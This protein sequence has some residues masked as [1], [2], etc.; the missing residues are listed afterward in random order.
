MTITYV[1]AGTAAHA[2]AT[3]VTPGLPAGISAADTLLVIDALKAD[4]TVADS[5]GEY[6][7]LATVL[8]STSRR[9]TVLGKT[10]DGS[11]SAPQIDITGTGNSH[12][13]VM[14]ALR[15]AYQTIASAVHASAGQA[16]DNVDLTIE[17]PA[18]TITEDNCAV[19][20]VISHNDDLASGALS[21]STPAGFTKVGDYDT[22][23]GGDHSFAIYEQIQTTATSISAGTV[24]K[25]GGGGA[26][27]A[28]IILA[29]KASV[30]NRYVKLLANAVAASET[31]IEGVVLNAARDTVIGEFSGQAFE[32]SLEGGEAVLLIPTN[33]ITPNGESLTTSDTPTVFAYNAT[34]STIGPGSATVI[35]V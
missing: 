17:Y 20:L 6:T 19:L 15:G 3:S 34:D 7:E 9:L 14:I 35:E 18:L 5:L 30:A 24:T 4:G 21:F 12:S 31:G 32:A 1:A 23:L 26:V 33:A 29:L 2:N 13:A 11:E 27:N 25:S 8:G 10:H 16:G 22:T 28:A